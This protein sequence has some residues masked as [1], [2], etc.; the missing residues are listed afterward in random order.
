MNKLIFS[1]F[2]ITPGFI[3]ASAHI[4]LTTSTTRNLQ[5]ALDETF[6]ITAIVGPRHSARP[7]R[8]AAYEPFQLLFE[9]WNDG[10]IGDRIPSVM[11]AN[12]QTWTFT[13]TQLGTYE[14][15]FDRH[16]PS[17]TQAMDIETVSVEVY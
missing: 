3:T 17:P 1:L 2:L 13:T 16:S 10:C 9:G 15:V 4:D 6:T 11:A 7:W 14:I 12:T 5:V 8:L